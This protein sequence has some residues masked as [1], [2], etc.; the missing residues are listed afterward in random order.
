M[1]EAD[2]NIRGAARRKTDMTRLPAAT[3]IALIG[4][5]AASLLMLLAVGPAQAQVVALVNGEPITALDV[6]QRAR[7]IQV[8]NQKNPSQKEVLEELIDDKLK[9]IVSKRFITEIPKREIENAY[10]NIAR[11]AGMSVEQFNKM[12]AG[13]GLSVEALKS[14]IHADFVWTQIIRG[15]FQASLQVGEKE[16]EVKLHEKNKADPVG[17]EFR[18]RPITFL[19][20]RGSAPAAFEARKRE[21]EGLRARFQGCD[22]GLRTAM[23]LADV[24]VQ[25]AMTRQS[26]DVG[27]QQRDVLEN[28]PVGRLTPPEITTKGVEFFAV[29]SKEP[30]A[31]SDTAGKRETRDAIYQERFQAL[32]KKYIK[33]LR[34]TALIEYR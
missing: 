4:P 25:A 18:L 23:A 28:T 1:R 2:L 27:Q 7:L 34:S 6:A 29:C 30:A 21:A 15:K 17:Y 11:R 33:E 13:S 16:V 31:S 26:A 3:R 32:S 12:V 8:S 5:L 19:V 20:P 9:V 10:A 22:E 14:R 24:V